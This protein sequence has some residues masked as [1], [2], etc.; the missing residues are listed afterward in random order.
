MTDLSPEV[1]VFVPTVGDEANFRDCLAHLAAQTTRFRL[2]IIRNIAPLSA[3]LQAMIDRCGTP[4]YAQVD[5]DMLLVPDAIAR[6]Y[7]ALVRA[8]DRVAFVCGYLWDCDVEHPIAG[9][10]MYRH[11]LMRQFPYENTFSC[12]KRQLEQIRQAGFDLRLLPARGRAACFGEHGKHYTPRTAFAR[13]RRLFFKQ[14]RYRTLGWVEPWPARLLER[15]VE[16]RDPLRLYAF[17]GAV[18]GIMGELP[19]DRESDF[20]EPLIEFERLSQYFPIGSASRT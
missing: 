16:S 9:V 20:R 17:L 8:P 19:P 1:T 14:R 18:A 11:S 7:D 2:E 3:A 10:K 4:Y 5:E 6:L 12:E 15:Y 13:W